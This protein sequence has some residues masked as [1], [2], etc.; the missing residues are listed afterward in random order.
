MFRNNID[1]YFEIAKKTTKSNDENHP[2]PECCF[3]RVRDLSPVENKPVSQAVYSEAFLAPRETLSWFLP[4]A[5]RSQKSIG[6][7]MSMDPPPSHG[8]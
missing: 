1:F 6:S 2:P 5:L 7:S 4:S 8:H 3:K